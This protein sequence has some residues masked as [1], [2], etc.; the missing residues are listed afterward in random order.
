VARVL[1]ADDPQVALDTVGPYLALRPVDNN[2]LLTL[3]H[4]RIAHPE[5]GKY[6]TVVN[7]DRVVGFGLQSPLTYSL[8]LSPMAPT[9]TRSLAQHIAGVGA[10][11]VPGVIADAGTA[12]AFAGAWS[13]WVADRVFPVEGQRIYRLG[14]LQPP[15]GVPGHL[16][17][18]RADE[19][20]ILVEWWRA[21][22]ADTGNNANGDSAVAVQRAMEMGHLFVWDDNGPCCCA[23]AV[24]PVAGVCRIGTV[25]T[26]PGATSPGL[27]RG[28]R[29]RP[30]RPSPEP[31]G[32][33]GD[34][35]AVRAAGQQHV[36][37]H[38]PA[39]RFPGGVGGTA[40][41]RGDEPRV[42]VST[43]CSIAGVE[44]DDHVLD[45]DLGLLPSRKNVTCQ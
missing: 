16:R 38:L 33:T 20:E 11:W 23:R 19:A 15:T 45:R 6:W 13:E 39:A 21:F 9:A 29:R 32:Q 24:P 30:V 14:H 1:E 3:L 25:Y 42:G 27:R 12:A 7:G 22:A 40:V 4:Q 43:G 17:L 18:A 44:M 26:P 2:I 31:A 10:G 35:H 8:A 36:E 37:R 34:L 28:V 5:P 41:P